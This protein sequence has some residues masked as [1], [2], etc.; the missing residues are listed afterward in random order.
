MCAP[1]GWV[2]EEGASAA[3]WPGALW[4]RPVG[5]HLWH[6]MG[7]PRPDGGP[8][9]GRLHVTGFPDSWFSLV[10]PWVGGQAGTGNR[11]VQA[12]DRLH[13]DKGVG[14]PACR[15]SASLWR[16]Q[17]VRQLPLQT[18]Q[19]GAPSRL[20]SCLPL[21]TGTAWE[22]WAARTPRPARAQGRYSR[23]GMG[24]GAPE[25]RE[26]MKGTHHS[27]LL[28][29]PSGAQGRGFSRSGVGRPFTS[30]RGP[31]RARRVWL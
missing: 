29:F 9:G 6:D 14:G 26:E 25:S 17:L 11:P 20:P 21:G 24:L 27:W 19:R 13:E 23:G 12:P 4:A 8:E 28:G 15:P 31:G 3:R 5:C 18:A 30:L 2:S 10:G 1:R 16:P 22:G 7:P